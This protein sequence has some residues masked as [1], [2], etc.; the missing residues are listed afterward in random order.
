[1]LENIFLASKNKA[2]IEGECEQKNFLTIFEDSKNYVVNFDYPYRVR[3][4]CPKECEI[5]LNG[6]KLEEV[7]HEFGSI[8]CKNGIIESESPFC[9]QVVVDKLR[10][11]ISSLSYHMRKGE[12]YI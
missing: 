8:L 12:F 9:R 6:E 5:W 2:K 3:V 10:P 7:I 4:D 11:V 1:M